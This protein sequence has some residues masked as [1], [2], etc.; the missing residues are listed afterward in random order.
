MISPEDLELIQTVLIES[1]HTK[2]VEK[3][4]KKI[5][6]LL[7]MNKFNEETSAKRAE[8]NQRVA[9]LQDTTT[10]DVSDEVLEN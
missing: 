10:D 5:D 1:E 3:L 6:L 9:E 2:A 7:E 4:I 8:Y